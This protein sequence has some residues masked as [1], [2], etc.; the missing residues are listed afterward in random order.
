[1]NM[2]E[3]AVN[4]IESYNEKYQNGELSLE[5]AQKR[6]KETI[7]HMKYEGDNYLWINDYNG[8]MLQHPS[9]KLIGSDFTK[10]TDKKGFAF[11][12][13]LI[14]GVKSEGLGSTEYWWTKGNDSN[15]YPKLSVARGFDDWKWMVA[16]GVYIDDVQA[17]INKTILTTSVASFL[18]LTILLRMP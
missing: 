18:I 13:V 14:K 5:E 16:S 15:L 9:E 17:A 1:M 8:T 7:G 2:T 11:V 10:V 12:P 3:S 6:A 4:I